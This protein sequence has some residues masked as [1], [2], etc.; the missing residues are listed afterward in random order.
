M[1]S[2]NKNSLTP[3]KLIA[4]GYCALITFGA[5]LLMLPISCREGVMTPFKNALFTATSA[6]CVTGLVVY[7]TYSHW[8]VFGQIVILSLIQIGGIG[9]M[10]IAISALAFTK[11]KIGLQ[12]RVT[13][14]ESVAAPQ[15]GGIVRM[16]KFILYGTITIEAIGAALLAFRF[17][18]KLGFI[19]GIYFSVF[20][21]IS[22]FCNAGIDL[23]GI[24]APSS[25]L[26]TVSSDVVINLTIAGLIAIGGLG[27]FVWSDIIN[28]K[29]HLR[30]YRLH[31]K[32]VIA[33][34]F[35]LIVAGTIIIFALEHNNVTMKDMTLPEKV[36]ASIF[37][38]V[39]PRT[40]G[41]NSLDLP[42]MTEA[43]QFVMIILMLIGGSPGS[44]AGG[45][46]TTTASILFLSIFT[47]FKK[48]KSIECFRR[49]IDDSTLRHA[50]C[51][52]VM[53]LILLVGGAVL[54]SAVDTV[55]IKDALYETTSAIG[56][57]GLSLGITP[58]LS[59]F[60]QAI[61]IMLMFVG[62][63]GGIT[64]LLAFGNRASSA[65]SQ[66]PV[67]KINVG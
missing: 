10:T 35:I 3:T 31:S 16:T 27:F 41:F 4:I 9:F 32:L 34:T 37:Q 11:K 13:M 46:K 12:Q 45:I 1:I 15:V 67:E 59:A 62:R 29:H 66:L 5:I 63:V 21:S 60:S 19:K 40:A 44:T 49:R 26:T 28:N 65:P 52:L 56:T 51:I 20:H 61:L 25:S 24:F 50:C 38:S 2:I 47:E 17:I 43:S 18:P 6:T 30:R 36:L 48:R 64:L 23:M 58:T 54:I 22:A 8:S 55:P 57:V 53:Y 14:Q 7:D 33:A 42:K 39:T